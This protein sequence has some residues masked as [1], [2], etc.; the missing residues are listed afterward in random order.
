MG[1]VTKLY[2]GVD[3]G[4]RMAQLKTSSGPINRHVVKLYPLKLSSSVEPE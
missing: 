3:G 1:K 2:Q 4:V